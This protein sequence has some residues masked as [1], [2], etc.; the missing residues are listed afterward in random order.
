MSQKKPNP[1]GKQHPPH[2]RRETELTLENL[3]NPILLTR[4]EMKS[5]PFEAPELSAAG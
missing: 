4:F 1:L 2:I 5:Y 3:E